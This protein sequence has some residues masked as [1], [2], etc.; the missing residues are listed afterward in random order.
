MKKKYFIDKR[1][2]TVAGFFFFVAAMIVVLPRI[3]MSTPDTAIVDRAIECEKLSRDPNPDRLKK[4]KER[5]MQDFAEYVSD[6]Q[7]RP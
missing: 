4:E 2:L 5:C 7:R 3:E 1:Y 6:H